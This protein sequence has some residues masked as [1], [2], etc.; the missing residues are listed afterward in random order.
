MPMINLI[1]EERLSVRRN[2][3]RARSFFLLF[4]ALAVASGTGFVGLSFL[5]E[6]TRGE[7]ARLQAER[8][9]VAP[10][11]DEI[12][13]HQSHL[14]SMGPLVRTLEDART[15]SERWSRILDH[16][17]RH[18]PADTW[19][20]N[21]RCTA[22]DPAKAIGVSFIGMGAS[23]QPIGEFMLRLQA[24]Q[25][26]EAVNLKYTTEKMV[27]NSRGTEFEI[28]GDIV[29]SAEEKPKEEEKE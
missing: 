26:L 11:L 18:T 17:S 3:A 1:Q 25:D 22:S 27:Q 13:Q 8:Q 7:G 15:V 2:E 12:E 5:A 14:S 9:K 28:N 21:L 24:S 29:G 19:L 4:V 10:L 20:T 6:R 16:L 23:Q